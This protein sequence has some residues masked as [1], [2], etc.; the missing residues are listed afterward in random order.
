M[1]ELVQGRSARVDLVMRSNVLPAFPPRESLTAA[2][3][4]VHVKRAEASVWSP[5]LL[6]PELWT[7]VGKGAYLLSLEESDTDTPGSLFVLVTGRTDV[8]PELVP[9]LVELEV[10]RTD[11]FSGAWTKVPMTTLVGQ[12]FSISGRPIPGAVVNTTLYSNPILLGTVAVCGEPVRTETDGDGFF[13]IRL[14]TGA[15]VE[16][17]IPAAHWKRMIVVPPPPAPNVPVRLFSIG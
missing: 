3:I 16:I 11:D 13:Q 1:R 17:A 14:V 6:T 12:V 4:L 2:D 8:T 5:K 9:V 10:V 15:S 7:D